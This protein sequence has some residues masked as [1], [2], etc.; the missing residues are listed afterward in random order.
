MLSL[1][2]HQQ[3]VIDA[4]RDGFKEGHRSQL[5][6]APT[7]FGKTEVAISLMNATKSKDKRS[8]MVLDR[9]VLVDQTSQRLE[10]Y[11]IEHGVYQ[12]DHWK[13]NTSEL[14]Q[15]CSSQTLER[16]QD[17]PKTQLLII[18]EC[19]ITRKDITKLIKSNPRLRVIGL[20]A[21]PFTRG[22][23]NIY[24]NVI[25][26]ATTDKLI[27]EKWLAPLKVYIAKEIDM[28]GAKKIAGEWSPEV[29]TQRGM[30]ITGDIVQEWIKKTH[31][32]FGRPRKTIVFCAGVAHGQDLVKQFA[33]KGYNFVS[34]SYRETTEFKRDVIEDFS[35]PDTEIHGLIATDILT[36]GFDVPDVM[37]G[38]SARPFSKSLSSHI[39]QM[40]RVMRP[41]PDKEFALWLDHSGNYIRFRAEWESVYHD[42][43]KELDENTV[44][45]AKREPSDKVKEEAKC[46]SCSALWEHGA[47]ECHA[48]GYIRKKPQFAS[49]EG[50]M[51]ELGMSSRIPVADK[52]AFYSE[53]LYIAYNKK[54]NIHWASHKYR[55][56]FGIW[57]KDL[58]EVAKTPSIAT[59][60]WIK[61][62]NIAYSKATKKDRKVA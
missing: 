62:R 14:I 51:L 39:Q 56:K 34:I 5:L 27:K 28:R 11:D 42:G 10:K 1:R 29:V 45:K 24:T 46:P 55:E 6:Y 25:C 18:D 9:I 17:F 54:Y 3:W 31:E 41:H 36:R 48:C 15:I 22:L 37:I 53:L 50:E 21:T 26:G 2:E 32:V 40:G 38:I 19:H 43:V 61:S 49:V 33:E 60:N 12:A 13:Y 52:Q 20:T 47:N 16:R 8:A 59:M 30:Q 58:E 57:P 23:G 4:L 7:G 35:K 44:E